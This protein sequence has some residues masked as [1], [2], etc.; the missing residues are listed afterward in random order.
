MNKT[1]SVIDA[2]IR[3]ARGALRRTLTEPETKTILK[4]YSIPVPRFKVIRDR[5]TAK[6]VADT[7][8]YP[9]ALKVISRELTHKSEAG[10]VALGMHNAKNVED[11]LFEIMLNVADDAPQAVIEGFLIEEMAPRG[12]EVIVGAIRDPVFGPAVMFGTG[13]LAV[14]ILKDVTFALSPIDREGA[15]EMMNEVKGFGLL[16]GARGGGFKDL[17]AIADVIMKVSR[18]MEENPEIT[19]LEINPL[20]VYRKGASAVDARA[21]L[22]AVV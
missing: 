6:A 12:V 1:A 9:L 15:F 21:T 13:G 10:G 5:E 4:A 11:G 3:E 19:E 8:T 2:L 17:D 7:L 14:E 16:T 18:I 22:T 20:I